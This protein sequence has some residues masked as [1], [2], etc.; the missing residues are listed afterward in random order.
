MEPMDRI[1]IE[2]RAH[3]TV[4]IVGREKDGSSEEREI[5]PYSIRPGKSDQL[6]LF[7]CL[8]KNGMRSLLARNIVS[9]VATGRSFEP[10]YP[11]EL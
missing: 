5:E 2:A 9:A 11:V 3:R 8:K 10:R 6:L 1:T 4:V 7:W